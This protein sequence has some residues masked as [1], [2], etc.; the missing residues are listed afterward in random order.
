LHLATHR[1]EESLGTALARILN[2]T[3]PSTKRS[4]QEPKAFQAADYCQ[5]QRIISVM[6]RA[7]MQ[8]HRTLPAS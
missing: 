7:T 8:F 2:I 5:Y 3:P 1:V 6:P 4:R